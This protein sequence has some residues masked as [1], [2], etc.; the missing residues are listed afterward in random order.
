MQYLLT[1]KLKWKIFGYVCRNTIGQNHGP[2]WKT[3]SFLLSEICT[4]ILWQGC[5]GN[6][7]S[8]KFYWD[9]LGK[10]SNL[11]MLIRSP[12][13]RTILVCIR[14]RYKTRWKET[15][16]WPNVESTCK[17]TSIWANRHHCLT[18]FIWVA[19]NE[20]AKRAKILRIIAETCLN[21]GSPQKQRKSCLV[22]GNLAR[23]FPHKLTVSGKSDANIS[24]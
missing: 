20:N 17:K 16:H 21:L 2:A 7:N 8:R 4:V 22:P 11:G 24:S 13:K 19:L 15:K 23:T 9:R 5:C 6:V 10:S 18:M 14:G 1:P 3:Q 12:R